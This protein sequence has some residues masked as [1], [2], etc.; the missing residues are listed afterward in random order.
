MTTTPSKS[1]SSSWLPSWAPN[2]PAFWEAGGKARAWRTLAVTTFAL[3]L[4]FAT[5]FMVSAI[6][7]RLNG[8]GFNLSK[9]QLFWLTAMPG[10]AAGLL[11]LVHM[12]LIPMYGSRHTLT[13]ATLSLLIPAVGW[14]VAVQNPQTPFWV[15]MLLA[16]AAGLGGGNFSSFMPSTNLFFPK[17][18]QGTALGIQAGIG[19]FGVSLTQFLT[20]WVVGVNLFWFV[21]GGYQ[22]WTWANKTQDIWLQNASWVYIPWLLLAALLTWL[23]IR[24]VPVKANFGQQFAIFR[25]KH[26]WVM[27]SI[28]MMTFGA[29]SGLAAAFPLLIKELYGGFENPPLPLKFA[30]YGPLIGSAVRVLFGMV[31]DRTGGAVLTTISALGM[32]LGA[33]AVTFFV[34]PTSLDSFPFFVAAMLAIFLFSGIGNASTF[35]QMPIIF[36]PPQSAGVIGWT[37]AIAA[38][39]PFIVSML[40]SANLAASGNVKAFFFGLAVFCALNLALNW[41]FYGRRGAEKPS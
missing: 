24:S 39:G 30:F 8:I 40:I 2:D 4:A 20:P 41:Y 13:L 29:F 17:H 1:R 10:L 15:L 27:T 37:A 7:V 22:A 21:P 11:R 6:V 12:F 25:D 26:T 9:S 38:F 23:L 28:Y 33:V 36:N 3:T 34:T 31:A 19:N 5:W 14:G 18:M 32:G 35:R 16:F